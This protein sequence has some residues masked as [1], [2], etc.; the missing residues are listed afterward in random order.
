MPKP[1]GNICVKLSDMLIELGLALTIAA[2]QS[3]IDRPLPAGTQI[4]FSAQTLAGSAVETKSLLGR[5]TVFILWGSW[6]QPSIRVLQLG[7][8]IKREFPTVKI[9]GLSTG[10]TREEAGRAARDSGVEIVFWWD[11]AGRDREN[12]IATKVFR[13][14][15]FPTIYVLD[16]DMKVVKGFL[17][18]RPSDKDSLYESIRSLNE[19]LVIFQPD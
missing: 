6:S 2:A 13:T 9:V 17:G 10:D 19:L 16:S 3:D 5:P 12:S 14:R 18:F 11:P 1:P 15:R 8:E 4:E 7:P